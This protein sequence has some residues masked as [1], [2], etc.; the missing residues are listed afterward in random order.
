MT[1][2]LSHDEIESLLGAFALDAVSPAEAAAVEAHLAD[3]ATCAAEVTGHREVAASLAHSYEEPPDGLW[4]R[5]AAEVGPS[6]ELPA[7][8]SRVVS[9]TSRRDEPAPRT[10]TARRSALQSSAPWL[11]AA[12]AVVVVVLLGGVIVRQDDRIGELE[13]IAA[14]TVRDLADAALSDPGARTFELVGGD[15]TRVSLVLERNGRGYVFADALPELAADR[16][17]QLWGISDDA[18]V[19][20]GVLGSEV[21]PFTLP[22]GVGTLAITEEVAGGVVASNRDPVVA[23]SVVS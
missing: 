17:Y 10:S 15:G 4:S 20:L 13:Q 12:A 2:D 19:S 1:P 11:A 3:C 8:L 23:G 21:A 9:L 18:V 5:I 16:T 14:P 7:E 22:A 6:R